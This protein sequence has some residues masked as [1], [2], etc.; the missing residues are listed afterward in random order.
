MMVSYRAL[1]SF[2]LNVCA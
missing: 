1:V 2:N